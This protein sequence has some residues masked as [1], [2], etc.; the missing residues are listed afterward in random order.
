MFSRRMARQVCLQ[1]RVQ[2]R[3]N[4][5]LHVAALEAQ[6]CGLEEEA[7]DTA[8]TLQKLQA[9]IEQLNRDLA[10]LQAT[11]AEEVCASSSSVLLISKQS[12]C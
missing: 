10:T 9:N 11:L 4:T 6:V 12:V 5:M 7:A 2:E 1:I 3:D 8:V